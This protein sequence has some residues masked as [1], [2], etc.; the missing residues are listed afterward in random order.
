MTKAAKHVSIYTDGGA[1]GNPGPAGIGAVI[2]GDDGARLKEISKSIGHATN[3]VAEYTAVI[4]GLQEALFLKAEEVDLYIDS[5]LV[6]E[7]L[8]GGYKVKNETLRPLFEQVLHLIQGFKRFSVNHVPREKNTD[9]DKLVNKA[10]NLS[11]L[12]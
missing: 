10:I 1:R 12:F 5:E 4:Y 7:Q 11:D 2:L 9:A 8:R 3:N 6:A